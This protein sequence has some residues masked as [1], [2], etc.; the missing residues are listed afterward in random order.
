MAPYRQLARRPADK[1]H[2]DDCRWTFS[3]GEETLQL[4]R[5][6][7]ADGYAL[8]ITNDGPSRTVVFADLPALLVFQT[9]MEAFLLKTGWSFVAFIPEQR[10]GRDRRDWPRL[11]ERR[12][13]WTDSHRVQSDA[14]PRADRRRKPRK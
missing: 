10:S 9:D 13:W 3:R 8:E 4:R 11:S 5:T 7:E 1:A 2:V 14:T 6:T 12:R